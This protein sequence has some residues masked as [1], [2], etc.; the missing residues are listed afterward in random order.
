MDI[1]LD[2]S[3]GLTS[4]AGQQ[5]VRDTLETADAPSWSFNG[6]SLTK[7]LQR[8]PPD[9]RLREKKPPPKYAWLERNTASESTANADTFVDFSLESAVRQAHRDNTVISENPQGSCL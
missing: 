5:M 1:W 4:S 3:H 2:S 8:F 7:P 9:D 6:C